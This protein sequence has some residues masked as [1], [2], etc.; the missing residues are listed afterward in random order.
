MENNNV[1]VLPVEAVEAIY[2]EQVISEYKN[3]PAIEALPP[4]L[5][6]EQIIDLIGNYPD[7][8]PKERELP[9]HY[10]YHCIPRI[11]RY[12]QP[13]GQHVLL[14]EQIDRAIRQGL[15]H[16]NPVGSDYAAALQKSYKALKRGKFDEVLFPDKEIGAFGFTV[17]GIPGGGKSRG[18]KRALSAYP[19]VIKHSTRELNL[20]QIT[21]VRIDCPYNGTLGGLCERYFEQIDQLIG[22]NYKKKF[23]GSKIEIQLGEMAHLAILHCVGVLI[24]DEIQHLSL[25]GSGGRDAMLNFFV[26]L[27]N[28]IGIP[29]ILVGTNKA[30]SLFQKEFR[31]ARRATGQGQEEMFWQLYKNDQRWDI[32]VEGLWRYQWTEKESLLTEEIKLT[33]FE[34]SQGIVDIVTKLYAIAQ[35]RAI[36]SGTE[37]IDAPFLRE[38]AKD[39]LKT[40]KPMLD[41]LKS[42][43]MSEIK[44]YEDIK[45]V[46]F[47]VQF[48]KYLGDLNLME[49]VRTYK[50]WEETK[51]QEEQMTV[52]EQV[53]TKLLG[54]GFD[55]K[56]VNDTADK[57]LAESKEITDITAILQEVSKR[58]L[59]RNIEKDQAKNESDKKPKKGGRKEDSGNQHNELLQT[60]EKGKS[61]K[62]SAYQSLSD[63][64]YVCLSVLPD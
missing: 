45:P 54:L 19:P 23:S 32:L 3:N 43:R 47:K 12:F 33:L 55:P 61:K 60:V 7:Y 18:I 62:Q 37:F 49:K 38:V 35:L 31:Q 11:F 2:T 20:F 40:V 52:K 10:R 59:L 17:I 50:Q 46:D 48:D 58:I 16:R 42:G 36:S 26:T 29:V 13:N 14:A 51:L 28:S 4:I 27:V 63:A 24:I 21:Y 1:Q 30:Y 57:V 6:Q 41:A 22:T 8:D 56:L 39:C 25:Q 9:A 5:A 34:E 44:N 15:I 53:V 64:G